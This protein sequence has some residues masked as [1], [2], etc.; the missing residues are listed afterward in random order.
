MAFTD[1]RHVPRA[2]WCLA[3]PLT[4]DQVLRPGY[5]WYLVLVV[6]LQVNLL[7]ADIYILYTDTKWL[8]L[9]R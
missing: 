4:G 6:N 2:C 3:P 1:A 7:V 8:W 5:T 9:A